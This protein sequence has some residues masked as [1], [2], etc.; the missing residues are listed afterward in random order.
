MAVALV[1]V[2]PTLL[3][4]AG[5]GG[6][7]PQGAVQNFFNAWQSMNWEAYKKAVNPGQKLTKNQEELAKLKFKQIKVKFQDLKMQS[8]VDP[9]DS[10]KATVTLVGG[11]IIYTADILGK[12]QTDTQDISKQKDRPVFDAVKINGVWYVEYPLG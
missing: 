7:T 4:L 5:C 9:K 10:N 11:K 8:K 3:V 6:N 1:L 12:Q 2:L